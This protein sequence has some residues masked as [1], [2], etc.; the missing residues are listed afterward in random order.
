MQSFALSQGPG[1]VLRH[2]LPTDQR[3]WT[4]PKA[5]KLPRSRGVFAS[6]HVVQRHVAGICKPSNS[7]NSI[8]ALSVGPRVWQ[9]RR[10]PCSCWTAG[11][12]YASATTASA[13]ATCRCSPL[14]DA[15]SRLRQV[16]FTQS[17]AAGRGRGR[18]R[19]GRVPLW[20]NGSTVAIRSFVQGPRS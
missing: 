2:R 16:A 4:E 19:T 9:W 10:T 7:N 3:T 6:R 17:P 18:G 1:F 20:E 5:I 13:S 12:R 11:Q 14:A 15:T 8:A